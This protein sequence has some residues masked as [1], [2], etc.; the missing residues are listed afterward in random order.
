M[1]EHEKKGKRFQTVPGTPVKSL[2]CMCA[3]SGALDDQN[4][5]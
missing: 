2:E 5:F 1:K 3:S 4:E